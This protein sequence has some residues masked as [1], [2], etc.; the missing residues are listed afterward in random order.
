MPK[1]RSPRISAFKT[2]DFRS[3]SK[4]WLGQWSYCQRKVDARGESFVMGFKSIV[5]RPGLSGLYL[6]SP[7][8]CF[9]GEHRY[10][11][12]PRGLAARILVCAAHGYI[13][14]QTIRLRT[15]MRASISKVKNMVRRFP[16]YLQ[17]RRSRREFE[18]LL[19]MMK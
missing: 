4:I 3:G 2:T 10:R 15:E 9:G 11:R 7:Y 16:N 5:T 18:K 14:D 12:L 19:R 1:H 8:F 13:S 6:D 17:E